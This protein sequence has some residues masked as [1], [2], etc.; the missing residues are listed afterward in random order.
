MPFLSI[1]G[2]NKAT[3]LYWLFTCDHLC[4]KWPI[5]IVFDTK[6]FPCRHHKWHHGC[7]HP[8]FH[9]ILLVIWRYR[10]QIITADMKVRSIMHFLK[11]IVKKVGTYSP[12]NAANWILLPPTNCHGS[13]A[14]S[15]CPYATEPCWLSKAERYHMMKTKATSDKQ[16][17]T[18]AILQHIV[19]FQP[20]Y[21]SFPLSCPSL[22]LLLLG[23]LEG[24]IV[25]QLI[26]VT[27]S[28]LPVIL[29][30]AKNNNDLL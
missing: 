19:E 28:P 3:L 25:R 8:K 11:I 30:F 1:F 7:W 21:Q 17:L 13:I 14:H 5:T 4:A 2:L 10:C 15:G 20:L 16:P 18:A 26:F 12:V 6:R 23:M 24:A 29:L 27:V 22:L 9:Q